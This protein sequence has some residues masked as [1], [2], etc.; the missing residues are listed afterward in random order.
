MSYRPIPEV[1][2]GNPPA[3]TG[4]KPQGVIWVSPSELAIDTRYQRELG[5]TGVHRVRKIALE[6]DWRKFTPIIVA[7]RGSKVSDGYAV[8]DGQHRVAAV[9]ARGDIDKVPAWEIDADVVGQAKTFLAINAEGARVPSGAI[10]YAKAA[11]G[12][13]DALALLDVCAKAG[14]E[15]LKSPQSAAVRSPERTVAGA[16][17]ATARRAHGD[18]VVIDALKVLRRGGELAGKCLLTGLMIRA[19]VLSA[20]HNPL[21]RH[22]GIALAVS[23]APLE[24]FEAKAKIASREQGGSRAEHFVALLREHLTAKLGKVAA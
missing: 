2:V 19:A 23:T 14:V 6:F 12:D 8:I 17:I 3:A 20:K 15:I 16:E 13:A 4:K 22:S 7:R 5:P 10:W 9:R 21:W 11:M 1:K 24:V 18:K